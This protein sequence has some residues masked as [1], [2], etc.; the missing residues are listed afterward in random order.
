[1][2]EY[3]EAG[4]VWVRGVGIYLDQNPSNEKHRDE[5][6][7]AQNRQ[8]HNVAKFFDLFAFELAFVSGISAP[9][10]T[11]AIIKTTPRVGARARSAAWALTIA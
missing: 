3:G 10:L 11:V 2:V 9:A 4:D 8:G 1:M 6:H 7:D 5:K